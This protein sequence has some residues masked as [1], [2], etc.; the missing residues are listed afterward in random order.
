MQQIW[1]DRDRAGRGGAVG[2]N[3]HPD[4]GVED[5]KDRVG[6]VP[7]RLLQLPPDL[8]PPGAAK[9]GDLL[10]GHGR[11]P[12][13]HRHRRQ[14]RHVGQRF[15]PLHCGCSQ[16]LQSVQVSVRTIEYLSESKA[17]YFFCTCLLGCAYRNSIQESV[18][19]FYCA[20]PGASSAPSFLQLLKLR[21]QS[22]FWKK[23]GRIVGSCWADE[24]VEFLSLFALEVRTI[25]TPKHT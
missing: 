19:T 15:L 13:L 10:P 12:L 2:R 1:S 11:A 25:A 6:P 22:F 18:C 17:K 9:H 21:M 3:T 8:L 14:R 4:V 23:V 20:N 24:W 5:V 16:H 7:L